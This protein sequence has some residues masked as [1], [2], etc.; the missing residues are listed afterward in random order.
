MLGGLAAGT[1]M[2]SDLWSYNRDNWKWDVQNKQNRHFQVQNI[3]VN[4]FDLYREDIDD[5]GEL[6]TGKMDAYLVVNTLKLGIV[7]TCFLN[8]DRSDLPEDVLN[9]PGTQV[10]TLIFNVLFCIS[11]LYLLLSIWLSMRGKV[12]T[13]AFVTKMKLHNVRMPLPTNEDIDKAAPLASAYETS[14]EDAFR[15]PFMNST[16]DVY[17]D[18]EAREE[19]NHPKAG[20]YDESLLNP[21]LEG[22]VEKTKGVS[23]MRRSMHNPMLEGLPQE[24][25]QLQK[26]PEQTAEER[27]EVLNEEELLPHL[28]LF[29]LLLK[30][31]QPYDVYSKITM[32]IGSSAMLSAI[33]FYGLYYE[34]YINPDDRQL[35]MGTHWGGWV[36]FWFFQFLS[37]GSIWLDLAVNRLEEFLLF[38]IYFAAPVS[39]MGCMSCG[40]RGV[41]L[42]P[43]VFVFQALWFSIL[44]VSAISFKRSLPHRWKVSLLVDII[45]SDSQE[46]LLADGEEPPIV[47]GEP[48]KKST[49]MLLKCLDL[50]L[51]ADPPLTPEEEEAVEDVKERLRGKAVEATMMKSDADN[52]HGDFEYDSSNALGMWLFMPI[53]R[54]GVPPEVRWMDL[55]R[56]GSHPMPVHTPRGKTGEQQSQ[57]DS[58]HFDQL[59]AAVRTTVD[60]ID[61]EMLHGAA[62]GWTMDDAVKLEKYGGKRMASVRDFES[63]FRTRGVRAEGAQGRGALKYF[64]VSTLI[65]IGTWIVATIDAFWWTNLRTDL[66]VEPP[67]APSAPFSMAAVGLEA[68]LAR[69]LSRQPF[70]LPTPWLNPAGLS[71]GREMQRLALLD[72]FNVFLGNSDGSEWHRPTSGWIKGRISAASFGPEGELVVASEKSGL[73]EL[74]SSF[75]SNA[76]AWNASCKARSARATNMQALTLDVSPRGDLQGI[77]LQRGKLMA[78]E[79]GQGGWQVAG[80]VS[81]PPE[82]EDP[83]AGA[84]KAAGTEGS[85]W[86]ALSLS[87]GR[88]LALDQ[89][90]RVFEL[91]AT[92][93][94]WRGPW[95]LSKDVSWRGI[96]A[97]P[98][99]GWLALGRRRFRNDGNKVRGEERARVQASEDRDQDWALWHF[100]APA[101]AASALDTSADR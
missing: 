54:Q 72:G 38:I 71:C 48:L 85:C 75:D 91:N 101:E 24:Q 1:D 35:V 26:G 58:M 94:T 62:A 89:R 67:L 96:C 13:N 45:S 51:D 2:F 6:T 17:D 86:A 92:T 30:N 82:L 76:L 36:T 22:K 65:V 11:F 73:C 84:A 27:A 47:I 66:P 61:A 5:L 55:S 50:L 40:D 81:R 57:G 29:R 68:P 32:T 100:E 43:V 69:Q 70:T 10:V 25:E 44:S 19:E 34:R 33:S 80:V 79:R 41:W 93:G 63:Q 7:V 9:P 12:I 37:F 15:V 90:G 4:R 64:A 52:V 78:V 46:A 23:H 53:R 56:D 39:F 49:H 18:S 59:L 3:I 98:E 77:A 74:S 60:A 14:T 88:A 99:V 28:K 87:F 21:K 20:G 83:C 97:L 16:G 42:L 31:W 8:Y 95:T